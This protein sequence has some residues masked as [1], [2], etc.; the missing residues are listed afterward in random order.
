MTGKHKRIIIVSRPTDVQFIT[1]AVNLIRVFLSHHPLCGKVIFT[2]SQQFLRCALYGC[3][4]R[5]QLFEHGC[6]V[7]GATRDKSFLREV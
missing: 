1:L 4:Y 5:I 6:L 3:S 7:E 2:F